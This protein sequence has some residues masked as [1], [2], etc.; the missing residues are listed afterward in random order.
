MH[1]ADSTPTQATLLVCHSDDK[2]FH[3]H[4]Q[5]TGQSPVPY[6]SDV[7]FEVQVEYIACWYIANWSRCDERVAPCEGSQTPR[8]WSG[9]S[10][11]PG[12][13]ERECL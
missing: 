13:Q 10:W 4:L 2:E 1:N 12:Y 6:V 11:W 7:L 9:A 5:E 8:E 3:Y